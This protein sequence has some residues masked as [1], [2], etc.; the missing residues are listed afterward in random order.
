MR[1]GIVLPI[2]LALAVGLLYPQLAAAAPTSTTTY[3]TVCTFDPHPPYDVSD[4]VVK[5]ITSAH[6][7]CV[8]TEV[9]TLVLTQCARRAACWSCRALHL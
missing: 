2:I 3:T 9:H 1:T 6:T 7:R 8:V 4:Q 5:A